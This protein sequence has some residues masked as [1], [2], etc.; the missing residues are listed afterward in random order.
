MFRTCRWPSSWLTL[1]VAGSRYAMGVDE[2]RNDVYF[3]QMLAGAGLLLLP[4]TWLALIG[5][6]R[7]GCSSAYYLTFAVFQNHCW[8]FTGD[9]STP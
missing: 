4:A 1:T 8:T 9:Y 2:R 6:G 5:T 7:C 3:A